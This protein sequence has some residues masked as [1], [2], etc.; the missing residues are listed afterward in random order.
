MFNSFEL[1]LQNS[2]WK[3]VECKNYPSPHSPSILSWP[4]RLYTCTEQIYLFCFTITIF[5][6]YE[7][8]GLSIIETPTFFAIHAWHHF[9]LNRFCNEILVLVVHVPTQMDWPRYWEWFW[10][11]QASIIY[12]SKSWC[13][14]SSDL[15]IHSVIGFGFFFPDCSLND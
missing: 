15:Q 11:V 4:L 1:F 2:F 7:I 9:L 14:G 5:D 6:C 10:R 3:L 13:W 8:M 12:M